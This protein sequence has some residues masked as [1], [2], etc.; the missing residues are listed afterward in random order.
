MISAKP[1]KPERQGPKILRRK[2]P[3]AAA[4]KTASLGSAV[5]GS[6]RGKT[7]KPGL[8]HFT[9][10]VLYKNL[11]IL[12][13]T[14]LRRRLRLKRKAKTRLSVAGRAIRGAVWGTLERFFTRFWGGVKAPFLRISRTYREVKPGI[15][16][17]REENRF[18][19]TEYLAVL[20]SVLR[21]IF[22]ILA[23]VFNYTAPVA[24]AALLIIIIQRGVSEDTVWAVKYDGET[25]GYI[26]N[27]SD[28]NAATQDVRSRLATDGTSAFE[29]VEPQFELL[30]ISQYDQLKSGNSGEKISEDAGKLE[31]ED[32][33]DILMRKSGSEVEEAYGLYIDDRFLG[34]VLD[35]DPVLDTF[36]EIKSRNHSGKP[37][38]TLQFVRGVRL[39][40]GLYP[41]SS[42]VDEARVLS[43]ITS[44]DTAE[45]IYIVK[46]NDTPTG[47]AD[48]TGVPY[49]TLK[50]LNPTIEEELFVGM[51][52]RTQVARPYMSV[53]S[54]YTDVVVE[55]EPYETIEVENA[56]YAKGYRDVFQDGVNGSRRVTYQVKSVDGYE[57]ERIEVAS[58]SLRAPVPERVTVG[59]ND[60]QVI[61]TP[62]SST[63]PGQS[64]SAPISPPQIT[65]PSNSAGFIW[66]VGAGGGTISTYLNGY[67]G[68]TGIDITNRAYRTNTPILAAA[69]GTVVVAK[70]GW[71]GYGRQ[72]IIDHGNGYQ[73]LYAHNSVLYVSVGDKVAQGQV[74]AMMGQTGNAYGV[75]LHFEVRQNGRIQNP[76]NYIGRR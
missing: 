27:R 46:E 62:P 30:T 31:Q 72:I 19:F 12:G 56:T 43:V 51:K 35:K 44:N 47:I 34:A 26:E 41:K 3:R 39:K 21:L 28:F 55:E 15:L 29:I 53:Q 64:G 1:P 66:P 16:S 70:N 6:A 54:T 18:P 9:L 50:L 8:W 37:D 60:P 22:K 49:E 36:D 23:T 25:I 69:S 63:S 17:K 68:H 11:Y 13:I 10:T 74:I 38:E 40:P 71:T 61:W 65:A 76:V 24:A 58:V 52:I 57:K 33:V 4:K 32:L 14:L 67:W 42:I 45:E 48:K 75:H 20:E 7:Q 5:L 2:G 73:T 59:I